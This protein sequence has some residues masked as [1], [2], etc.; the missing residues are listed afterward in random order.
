[1]SAAVHSFWRAILALSKEP[2]IHFFAI[3]ALFFVVQQRFVADPRTIVINAGVRADVARRFADHF[4]R[5]PNPQELQR[6][7]REWKHDEALYREALRDGLDREDAT[8]RQVLAGKVRA[9]AAS[10]LVQRQP[11]RAE[12]EQWRT[13]HRALYETP[14]RYDFEFVAF[15]RKTPAVPEALEHFERALGAG[16]NAASL[17]RPVIGGILTS[18]EISE[19]FGAALA[20]RIPQLS[21]GQWARS[22]REQDWLLVRVNRV[23]GG[24]P[25]TEELHDRL[26]VD[27]SRAMEEKALERAVEELA[28]R[29]HFVE[30]P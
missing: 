4:G 8:I 17:G 13:Q 11:S 9:R 12:L 18:G 2:A 29:Y 1:M 15:E 5:P 21:L 19:R 6:A 10:A 23:Q 30:Q 16:A 7:I 3:G 20:E 26:V 28:S 27:W 25:S 14:L 22:K 24:L